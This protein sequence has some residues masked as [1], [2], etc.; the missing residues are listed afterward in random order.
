M[1]LGIPDMFNAWTTASIITIAACIVVPSAA[2]AQQSS[3]DDVI[4]MRRVIAPPN[5]NTNPN[6][7]PGT[8]PGDVDPGTDPEDPDPIDPD[9]EPDPNAVGEWRATTLSADR[10][11]SS[12]AITTNVIIGGERCFDVQSGQEIGEASCAGKPRDPLV[13]SRQVSV[14]VSAPLRT[15]FADV[16]DIVALMPKLAN[17]ENF[18]ASKINVTGTGFFHSL[19]CDSDPQ[20][21]EYARVPRTVSFENGR[22]DSPEIGIQ[23]TSFYCV[24]AST[25]EEVSIPGCSALPAPEKFT[26][27]IQQSRALRTFYFDSADLGDRVPTAT[28]VPALCQ[29][30]ASIRDANLQSWKS[31]CDLADIAEHYE[32]YATLVS[33]V[34]QAHPFAANTYQVTTASAG[35]RCLD[36]STGEDALDQS[37][38]AWIG[39][40]DSVG[41]LSLPSL[42]NTENRTVVVLEQDLLARAPKLEN[43][44][45]FCVS[46]A[47]VTVSGANQK[48]RVRCNPAALNVRFET[49]VTKLIPDNSTSTQQN[50]VLQNEDLK[51]YLRTRVTSFGCREIETGQDVDATNCSGLADAHFINQRFTLGVVGQSKELRTLVVSVAN[52]ENIAPLMVNSM[53]VGDT[54][55]STVNLRRADS[56]SNF[57]TWKVRCDPTELGEHYERRTPTI[58]APSNS[59]Y[60]SRPGSNSIFIRTIGS[61]CFDTKSGQLATDSSK[62]E[63][64]SKGLTSGSYVELPAQQSINLRTI[65][66]SIQDLQR[67]FPYATNIS[68]YCSSTN[69]YKVFRSDTSPFT[70]DWKVRCDPSEIEEHYE[71][72]VTMIGGPNNNSFRDRDP[73]IDSLSVRNSVVTCYDTKNNREAVDQTKCEY[74]S[75]PTTAAP[76]SYFRVK[77]RGNSSNKTFEID[78]NDIMRQRPYVD[79][80]SFCS[81]IRFNIYRPGTSNTTDT[82][83]GAC[84]INF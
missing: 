2:Q 45:S 27:P 51:G 18:C 46:E 53:R 52:L 35:V 77:A 48:W 21:I 34:V 37:K 5:E 7:S 56:P 44:D 78:R 13:G 28:N 25:G 1:I 22:V 60:Y 62:C 24:R 47:N 42:S 58:A 55:N 16:D 3:D 57:Y 12:T 49:Y 9:P 41:I 69:N 67:A 10:V 61:D 40:P 59:S 84:A 64:I 15:V 11:T 43:L 63:F 74:L 81:Y 23:L 70:D 50:S 26:I 17:L 68:S 38:C 65:Y 29:G 73:I 32:K 79:I 54:C 19:R 76:E 36:T 71:R 30:T 39:N 6:P 8:D 72:R 75:G 80:D 31:R 20:N 83:T 33:P 4:V 82:W 66:V 14:L